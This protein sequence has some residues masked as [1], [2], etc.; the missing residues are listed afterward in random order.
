MFDQ[1]IGCQPEHSKVMYDSVK[2]GHIIDEES[3][4]TLS[5]GTA[6]GIEPGAVGRLLH[7][8]SDNKF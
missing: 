6:G 3:L 8:L 1:V 2:A 4:E 5:D 7:F